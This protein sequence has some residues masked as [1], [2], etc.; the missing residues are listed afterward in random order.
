MDKLGMGIESQ[1]QTG[2]AAFS[3]LSN[4]LTEQNL[5]ILDII[6]TGCVPQPVASALL[7]E[8]RRNNFM[9]SNGASLLAFRALGLDSAAGLAMA[10]KLY[11]DGCEVAS[12]AGREV[13]WDGVIQQLR[14]TCSELN[15]A[16]RD[17]GERAKKALNDAEHERAVRMAAE[18]QVMIA[19]SR[20]RIEGEIAKAR[21]EQA[22]VDAARAKAEVEQAKVRCCVADAE[23]REMALRRSKMGA[24]M[25][26]F[27][28]FRGES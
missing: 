21:V 2:V 12:D 7:A 27:T 24:A 25:R 26:F 18:T 23:V 6:K 14:T 3:V 13:L 15:A 17:R 28:W 1:S 8:L 11:V 5:A 4:A 19:T 20:A 10:M 9:I 22:N 16:S